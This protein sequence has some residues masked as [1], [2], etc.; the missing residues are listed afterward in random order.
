MLA[1]RQTMLEWTI[2]VLLA[3]ETIVLVVELLA[4][5]RG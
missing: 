5:R 3:A 1:R 4:S 2:I